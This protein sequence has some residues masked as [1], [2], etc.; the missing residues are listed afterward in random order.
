M[1]WNVLWHDAILCNVVS[2]RQSQLKLNHSYK[3][4][5]YVLNLLMASMCIFANRYD[6][7]NYTA[8]N[9]VCDVKHVDGCIDRWDLFAST[10]GVNTT[11]Y[12]ATTELACRQA[13]QSSSFCVAFDWNISQKVCMFSALHSYEQYLDGLSPGWNHYEWNNLSACG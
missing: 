8:V 2:Y 4:T 6:L 5:V 3:C 12:A 7:D 1:K 9:H 10:T 13:C 11:A